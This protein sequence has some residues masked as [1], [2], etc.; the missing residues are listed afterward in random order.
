MSGTLS[1]WPS[2]TKDWGQ[3]WGGGWV[4]LFPETQGHGQLPKEGDE[5]GTDPNQRPAGSVPQVCVSWLRKRNIAELRSYLPGA[6]P[7]HLSA[8]D[9]TLAAI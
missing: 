5:G 3:D 1:S 2:M 6:D 9:V 7:C 4:P 8:P